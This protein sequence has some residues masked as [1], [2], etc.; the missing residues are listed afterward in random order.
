[1]FLLFGIF[2]AFIIVPLNAYIQ[3]LA[4]SVH[5][6]TILAGNNFIQNIFM[7]TFLSITTVFA[8]LGMDSELLFYLMGLV[9]VFLTYLVYKRYI[10][11][12]FWALVTMLFSLRYRV[13]YKGLENI[14]NHKGVLLLGNHVSWI[15]WLILQ[16]P[17][18]KRINFVMSKSIYNKKIFTSGLKKGEV[19]PISPSSFKDGMHEASKRLKHSKI[20]AL[21]PEGRVSR[22]GELSEFKKGFELLNGG[23]DCV[24]VPF[25]IDGMF[26]SIFARNKKQ[27]HNSIFKR[28]VIRVEFGTPIKNDLK[29]ED[30]QKLIQNMKDNFA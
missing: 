10:V 24:V 29:A 7:F 17:L 20:V 16:L 6:G 30:L 13:E 27:Q 14:P 2:T 8:Y 1:M 3:H 5:L 4:P 11:M 25:F 26:G 23:A 19:I 18:R 12:A 21:Y 22:D 9:G 15:D 28:R